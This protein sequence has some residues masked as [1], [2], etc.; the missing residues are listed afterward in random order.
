M[1]A[2][3]CLTALSLTAWAGDVDADFVAKVE[4]TA[5]LGSDGKPIDE[6]RVERNTDGQVETLRLANMKLSAG[7]FAAIGKI[8]SLKHLDLYRTNV[9]DADLRSL[10]DLPL[11]TGINLTSTEVTDAAIDDLIKFP[12]LQSLCLGDV[13]ITPAAIVRLKEHFRAKDKRLAL[14]YNQRKP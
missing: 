10:G 9:T 7:D 11:L 4:K 8:K 13:A 3:I 14:G 6:V 12:A 1:Y 2:A 5:W